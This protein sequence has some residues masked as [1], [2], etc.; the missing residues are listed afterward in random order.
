MSY[1][2]CIC[3]VL[4]LGVK[5]KHLEVLWFN[6]DAPERK[7]LLDDARKVDCLQVGLQFPGILEATDEQHFVGIVVETDLYVEVFYLEQQG[8]D[9]FAFAV[10]YTYTLCQELTVLLLLIQRAEVLC[11]HNKT[12]KQ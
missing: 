12:L 9:F 1:K 11:C 2:A 3:L 10:G 6:S 7:D 5:G 8:L 4:P